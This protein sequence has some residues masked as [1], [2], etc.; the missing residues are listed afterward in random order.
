MA[1]TV[2]LD[3]LGTTTN[4]DGS[5][6]KGPV[7]GT[8]GEEIAYD[9]DLWDSQTLGDISFLKPFFKA[10]AKG[11]ELH[12][13]NALFIREIYELNKSLMFSKIDPIFAAIDAI[14]DEI[15]KLLADLRGLGFFMLPVHAGAVEENVE[16]KSF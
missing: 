8:T 12:K 6:A 9:P 13:A 7:F 5:E 2:D 11:L 15:L 3:L 4:A 16:R 14:L 1:L 10:S